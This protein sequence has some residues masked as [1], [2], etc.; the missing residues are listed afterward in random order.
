VDRWF[1]TNAGFNRNSAQQRASNVRTFP[2]RFGHV[3]GDAQR[4]WDASIKKDFRVVERVK[5]EFRAD[6]TNV[7]NSPIFTPPN[8]TVTSSGFGQVTAVA[9]PGRQWQFAMKLRY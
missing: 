4:R 1:N 6:A 5:L 7:L 8:T 2:L 3:R 9:W